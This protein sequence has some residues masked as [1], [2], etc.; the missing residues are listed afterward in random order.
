MHTATVSRTRVQVT[1]SWVR[2]LALSLGQTGMNDDEVEDD[3]LGEVNQHD[4]DDGEM[5]RECGSF[6]LWSA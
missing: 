2:A 4:E 3:L 5:M 1:D 6:Y